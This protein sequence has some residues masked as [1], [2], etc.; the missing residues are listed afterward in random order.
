MLVQ[1]KAKENKGKQGSRS[2]FRVSGRRSWCYLDACRSP[3]VP[4]SAS[5]CCHYSK[6]AD[7]FYLI[8]PCP[9][10]P[11]A[12]IQTRH[13]ASNRPMNESDIQPHLALSRIGRANQ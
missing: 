10:V 7:S 9:G 11:S 3:S 1:R 13:K 8:P 4:L 2:S 6:K 12:F 5:D